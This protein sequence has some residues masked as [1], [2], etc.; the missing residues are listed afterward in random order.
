MAIRQSDEQFLMKTVVPALQQA[1]TYFRTQDLLLAMRD[2]EDEVVSQ[3]TAD[4]V[5][6]LDEL[7]LRIKKQ[8]SWGWAAI[9]ERM[10]DIQGRCEHGEFRPWIVTATDEEGVKNRYRAVRC[11]RCQWEQE[12]TF[13]EEV[14]Q[15]QEA[16]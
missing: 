12:R 9:R 3:I 8:G 16:S 14:T 2:G 15:A 1:E 10:E 7:C 4:V 6:A 13:V 11:V 5:L